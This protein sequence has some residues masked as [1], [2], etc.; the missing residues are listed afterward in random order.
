MRSSS[1]ARR[2]CARPHAP[3]GESPKVGPGG[4]DVGWGQLHL[5]LGRLVDDPG[6]ELCRRVGAGVGEHRAV[7][8]AATPVQAGQHPEGQLRGGLAH[9]QSGSTTQ[10]VDERPHR[11]FHQVVGG[12]RLVHVPA[13]WLS[14]RPDREIGE[15]KLHER[16]A[17]LDRDR[18]DPDVR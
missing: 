15:L 13:P 5:R 12:V 18:L 11:T 2:P 6:S 8:R 17:D 9:P 3:S 1:P 14:P 4:G 10:I 7:S 16:R